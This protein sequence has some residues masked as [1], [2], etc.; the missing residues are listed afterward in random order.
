MPLRSCVR[1]RESTERAVLES[2]TGEAGT[3]ALSLRGMPILTCSHGHRQFL[4]ADFPRRLMEHLVDEDE[5]RL[6]AGEEQGLLRK[7]YHCCACGAQLQAQ[8]D[9]RETFTLDLELDEAGPFRV[10]LVAPVYRCPACAKEQLHSL[11]E[12]RKDTPAALSHAFKA[13]GI[14]PA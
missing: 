3:L 5:L 4:D 8:A 9:H 10:E 11:K 6:P 7:R 14:P 12:V 13:A 2:V 1:C